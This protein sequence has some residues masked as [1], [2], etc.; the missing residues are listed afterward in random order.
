MSV[1]LGEQASHLI[2]GL[3]LP[4]SINLKDKFDFLLKDEY[5]SI[6]DRNRTSTIA[7]S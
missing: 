5:Q 3:Q 7:F 6:G 2:E 1:Y 4:E